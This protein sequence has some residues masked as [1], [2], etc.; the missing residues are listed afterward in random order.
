MQF[1]TISER[2]YKYIRQFT[3]KSVE[4]AMVELITNCIDAYG[5]SRSFD[6]KEKLVYIDYNID[7]HIIT[8]ADNAIGMHADVMEKCFLS[9]GNYTNT[10]G[11]RGFFS[12]GAKDVSAIG[13][14][15]FK[16]I[17]DGK[18]SSCVLNNEAYG[19]ILDNRVEATD[20]HYELCSIPR[21]KN[22]VSVSLKLLPNFHV[23]SPELITNV[24]DISS[25]RSIFT[26]KDIRVHFATTNDQKDIFFDTIIKYEE[27]KGHMLMDVTYDIPGYP[28]HS[29]RFVIYKALM[30][31]PEP[32]KEN[33]MK[34]GFLIKD[35][36]TDYEVSTIDKRFRW[37]PHMNMLY[38]YLQCNGINE[39]LLDYDKN[40]ASPKNPMPII[41]PSRLTGINIEHPF[42][43]SL[44][45]IPKTR[46]DHVL[47]ELNAS[48]SKKSVAIEDVDQLIDELDKLGLKIVDDEDIMIN[49]IP[50]YDE[51][52]ANEIKTGREQYIKRETNYLVGKTAA[53][54]PSVDNQIR[55]DLVNIKA[56]KDRA[57]VIDDE[58]GD[59][60][61]VGDITDP[62]LSA[63][64]GKPYMYSLDE[65]GDLVKIYIFAKGNEIEAD[66]AGPEKKY[67]VLK[68]RKFHISFINDIGLE[69]RYVV[70][71][72]NGISIKLNIHNSSI[73]K[74][75]VADD[76]FDSETDSLNMKSLGKTQSYVFMQELFIDILSEVVLENNVKQGQIMLDESSFANAKKALVEKSRI[77]TAIEG[78]VSDLFKKYITTNINQK[79]DRMN[80]C[81]ECLIDKIGNKGVHVGDDNTRNIGDTHC[82]HIFDKW[83]A[84]LDVIL[85]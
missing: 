48:I 42:V 8:V 69:A 71:N 44:L 65:E 59:I 58:T 56:S 17:K 12:R 64:V 7:Q 85:E 11:S 40:G 75:L 82:D 79:R 81:I 32:Q 5:S 51:K 77:A 24:K 47:R 57:Y 66:N 3:I 16:S 73:S 21:G 68:N 29:A 62:N 70:D 28:D 41:D 19:S 36:T 53:S 39:L 15:H 37:K 33:K 1:V 78:P 10:E 45:S 9:V 63:S 52:L 23:K 55:D 72:D 31:I 38:G 60:V 30:P 35:D 67:V 61:D 22:G 4:D 80:K 74:Y 50:N 43:N 20:E 46:I 18:Y 26:N 76:D 49:Y 2:A 54:I 13:D 14:L 25:L 6:G 34:F 84:L 27:P 83:N